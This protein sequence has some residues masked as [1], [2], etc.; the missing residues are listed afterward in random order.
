MTRRRQKAEEALVRIGEL[1]QGAPLGLHQLRSP[2]ELAREAAAAGSSGSSGEATGSSAAAAVEAPVE[3]PVQLAE[4]YVVAGVG[5]LFHGLLEILPPGRLGADPQLGVRFGTCDGDEL[6]LDPR[7]RVRRFDPEL[8]Q[9]VVEGSSLERWLWGVLE[10]YAHLFDYLGKHAPHAFDERGE[11]T[12]ECTLRV[13]ASQLRRDPAAVAPRL[14]RATLMARTSPELARAELEEV[15]HVAPELAWGWLE[16]AKISEAKGELTGALDEARVAAEVAETA[17][18]PQA[19]YFWAHVARLC[20]ASRDEA[21]R[22]AAAAKVAA[23]APDMRAAQLAGAAEELAAG[24]VTSA[25]HLGELLHA[26]W[27]EDLEVLE[28]RRRIERSELRSN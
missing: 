25:V 13:L 19:G 24:E 12:E 23:L 21:G 16:L 11:V 27:P 14:R 9:V 8:D 17:R 22:A 2:G 5:T 18:H 15:V 7:G 6:W 26:V 10:G 20:V 28:L 4:I 1:L 3:A